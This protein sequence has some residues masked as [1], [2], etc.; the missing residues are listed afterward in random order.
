MRE[1]YDLQNDPAEQ[2]NL[3]DDHPETVSRLAAAAEATRKDLGDSYTTT[4]KSAARRRKGKVKHPRSLS[5]Y[6]PDHPYIIAIYD[7]KDRG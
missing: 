1:L 4:P 5:E 7:V 6:N 3:Y 2:N